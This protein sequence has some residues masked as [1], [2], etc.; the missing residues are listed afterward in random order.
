MD[1]NLLK[2]TNC[3]VIG[4]M[5]GD[6]VGARQIRQ[7][8]KTE[9]GKLNIVVWD[10]LNRPFDG[11][12][13][14]TE[15]THELLEGYRKFGRYDLIEQ[16]ADIRRQDLAMIDKSDFVICVFHEKIFSAGTCEELFWANRE[17][18]PI[19]FVWGEGKEKCPVW[20]FWTLP[21]NYIYSSVEEVLNIIK[22][23]DKG[24]LSM[25]SKRWRLFKQEF[26]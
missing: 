15:A 18:K 26:R 23:L 17:K 20:F 3:V 4:P 10:H 13:E 8:I 16:Y 6:M 25:D 9:L 22:L 5:E 21:H 19:F 7:H 12:I 1:M 11:F 2:D 24:E 14:E